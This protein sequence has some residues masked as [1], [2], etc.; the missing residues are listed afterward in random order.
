M[1]LL[2]LGKVRFGER[3]RIRL[4][5]RSVWDYLPQD[6]LRIRSS[7]CSSGEHGRGSRV[8]KGGICHEKAKETWDG[9]IS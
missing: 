9:R 7:P 1:V 3:A 5:R 4:L 8:I 2:A 6:F